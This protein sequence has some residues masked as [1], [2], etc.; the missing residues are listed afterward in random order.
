MYKISVPLNSDKT[1]SE[2]DAVLKQLKRAGV[3]R[4]FLSIGQYKTDGEERKKIFKTLKENCEFFKKHGF[5]TGVWMW[6]FYSDAPTG[7]EHITGANG[8]V[9]KQSKLHSRDLR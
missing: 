6:A 8:G 5:E 2:C 1:A 9:N 3:D 4:V 7:F